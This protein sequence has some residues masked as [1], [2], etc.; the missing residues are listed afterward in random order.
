MADVPTVALSSGH[1]IPQLGFGVF[2]VPSDQT[3]EV[4]ATALETGYRSIDTAAMYGNEAGVGQAIADSGL[5]RDELFIAT[6]LNND[7]HGYDAALAAFEHTARSS[8]STTSTF[9]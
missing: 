1:R 7:A 8:G 3:R 4:V 6:K 2:K 5:P 9:T